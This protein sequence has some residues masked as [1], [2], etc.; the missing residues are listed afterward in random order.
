MDAKKPP[1]RHIAGSL[2]DEPKKWWRHHLLELRRLSGEA[3]SHSAAVFS[4][5]TGLVK[6]R[7]EWRRTG[8]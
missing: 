7:A 1:A 3:L 4:N 6:S 8:L 5:Y 2:G